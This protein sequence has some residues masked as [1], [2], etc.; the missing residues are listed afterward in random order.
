M[1]Q[2]FNQSIRDEKFPKQLKKSDASSIF[3]KRDHFDKSNY[4]LVN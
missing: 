4:Q 3:Q 2:D 1:L